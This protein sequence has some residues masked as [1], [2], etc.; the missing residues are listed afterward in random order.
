MNNQDLLQVDK[1]IDDSGSSVA[2]RFK[3]GVQAT[4]FASANVEKKYKEQ[5]LY[6][7]DNSTLVAVIS[8]II[9]S[10]SSADFISL[11]AGDANAGSYTSMLTWIKRDLANFCDVH[12]QRFR[13]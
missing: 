5:P 6:V 9:K 11:F 2:F 8:Q 10:E 3:D 12:A 1:L 4:N 7:L 13:F